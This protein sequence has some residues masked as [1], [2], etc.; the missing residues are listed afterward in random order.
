M[1]NSKNKQPQTQQGKQPNDGSQ[2]N[3]GNQGNQGDKGGMK[4]NEDMPSRNM[5][6]EDSDPDFTPERPDKS[7]QI[8]DNPDETQKKIPNMHK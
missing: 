7:I 6:S 8:D 3:K 1:E 4:S 2:Q 5:Q